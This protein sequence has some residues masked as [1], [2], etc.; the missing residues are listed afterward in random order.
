MPEPRSCATCGQPLPTWNG[1]GRPRKYCSV[2]CGRSPHYRYLRKT[3]RRVPAPPPGLGSCLACRAVLPPHP[4]SGRSDPRRKFCSPACKSAWHHARK[5]PE[6][7]R[8]LRPCEFCGWTFMGNHAGHRFCDPRCAM[9]ARGLDRGLRISCDR[10]SVILWQ[11]CQD[12]GRTWP[13][14]FAQNI[15]CPD[16]KVVHRRAVKRM[17]NAFRRG[18][19]TETGEVIADL[20]IFERDGWT[21]QL[22]GEPVLPFIKGLHPRQATLDHVVPV[23]RGGEHVASNLQ[24]A[25]L[26]CN[27]AKRDRM[28]P[29]HSEGASTSSLPAAPSGCV[30]ALSATSAVLDASAGA[31]P[32]VPSAAA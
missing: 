9:A 12:C 7:Q 21:C 27:S 4:R 25:H 13:S 20:E 32:T 29:C 3:K 24:L 31:T 14:S 26:G 16:C 30:P 1:P 2:A 15:R 19:P 5:P 6:A 10:F 8:G 22:C 18:A 23:S 28:V 11:D 17:R